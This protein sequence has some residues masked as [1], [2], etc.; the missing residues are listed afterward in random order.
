M[1]SSSK[2]GTNPVYPTKRER[3]HGDFIL[4]SLVHGSRIS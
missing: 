4:N 3:D 2:F 1:L